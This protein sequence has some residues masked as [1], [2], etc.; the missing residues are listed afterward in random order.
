MSKTLETSERVVPTPAHAW[1]TGGSSGIGFAASRALCLAGYAVHLTGRDSNKAEAAAARLRSAGHHATAVP[2]DVAD[3]VQCARAASQVLDRSA[4]SL[5]V[6]VNSAGLNIANRSWPQVSVEG[7][8][9][10]MGANLDGTFHCIQAVLPAMRAAKCGLIVN[11]S[12]WAGRFDSRMAGPAYGAAKHAVASLSRSINLE[13]AGNGI[14]ATV[15]YPGEVATPI[16]DRRAV[17]PTPEM[18]AA[19]LQEDDMQ[20]VFSFLLRLPA[21]VCIAELS[22]KS[23]HSA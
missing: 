4:G 5:G 9:S 20:E 10:V 18:R 6:L 15:L 13:E 22:V 12:S 11:V 19:M 14:R 21:H 16:M 7:W 1:V 8:Q 23:V 2:A 3:P 17:P